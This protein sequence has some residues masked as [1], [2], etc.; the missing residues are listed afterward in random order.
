[1]ADAVRL[2]VRARVEVAPTLDDVVTAVVRTARP[3]DLVIT[4]G[5][6]SIGTVPDRL[7]DALSRSG[8]ADA[9]PAAAGV[10]QAGAPPAA[11]GSRDGDAS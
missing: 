6:G 1:L 11:P 3:G 5:A 10:D 4:L 9:A 7:I 8:A 2:A